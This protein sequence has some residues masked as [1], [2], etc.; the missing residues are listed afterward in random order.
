MGPIV[1]I[2]L[3]ND[4]I[5]L[6]LFIH[7]LPFLPLSGSWGHAIPPFLILVSK[8]GSIVCISL[9]HDCIRHFSFVHLLLF[10]HSR[11]GCWGHVISPFLSLDSKMSS[12]VCILLVHDCI[13]LFSLAHLLFF[14][15]SSW[16]GWGHAITSLKHKRLTLFSARSDHFEFS[17]LQ[18]HTDLENLFL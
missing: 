10:Y 6:F 1:C 12:I 13:H 4:C 15:T 18:Q 11:G 14:F 9:A 16:R 5:P 3:V 2:S 8:I 17:F 7:L